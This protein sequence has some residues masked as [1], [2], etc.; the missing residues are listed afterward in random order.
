[1]TLIYPDFVE[2]G[3]RMESF[4]PDGKATREVG[5]RRNKAMDVKEASKIMLHA[6]AQRKRES[7]LST[8]GKF[9]PLLKVL[10]PSLVDRLVQKGMKKADQS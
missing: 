6:I 4:G 8:R 5:K 3:A 10:F 7:I 2:T 9:I 1:M